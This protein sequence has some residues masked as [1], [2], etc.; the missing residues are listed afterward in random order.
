VRPKARRAEKDVGAATILMVAGAAVLLT[1]VGATAAVSD[2]V[3]T[4]QRAGTAA[5]LAALAAAYQIAY[6]QD[7]A[8]AAARAVASRNG[9]HLVSC[10]TGTGTG[11]DVDIVTAIEVRGS[12]RAASGWLGMTAPVVRS[13]AVAGPPPT[14]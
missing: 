10:H 6:G 13:R 7:Q 14:G 8:C 3:A 11:L 5:D 9:A 12:L 4:G 2:L 1:V